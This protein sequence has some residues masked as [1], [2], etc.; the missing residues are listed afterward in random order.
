MSDTEPRPRIRKTTKVIV[1][2]IA[3]VLWTGW[4]SQWHTKGCDWIL[5]SYI[6]VLMHGTPDRNEGCEDGG[7]GGPTYTDEYRGW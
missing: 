3:L 7:P 4:A 6:N 2:L 1:A 5:D